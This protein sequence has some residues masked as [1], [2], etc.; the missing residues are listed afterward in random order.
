MKTRRVWFFAAVMALVFFGFG[1]AVAADRSIMMATTTSTVDTGL[2]DYLIPYFKADTGIDLKYVY[3]GTGKALEIARNGDVDCVLVHAKSLE[4]KFVAEGYGVDRK[5]VA[6]NNFLVIGPKSDPAKIE[7]MKDVVAAFK[8]IAKEKA[9]FI[10][11]GDNSGTHVKELAIWKEAGITPQ[12]D[13]YL[14]SGAGIGPTLMLANEKGAYTMSDDSTYYDYTLGKKIDL[15]IM[16][17]GDKIL[18]NQYAII[19]VNPKKIPTAKYDDAKIFADWLTGEKGQKL[20]ADFRKFD[21]Q[22]FFPN[23][24][25]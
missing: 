17:M 7:G 15:P 9:L 19:L 6:Y 20:I 18:F 1:W 24:A 2:L 23:A 8:K 3:A 22:L 13:W 11:R 12:G 16:V 10:S 14:E 5:E 25:K 4:D 21:K